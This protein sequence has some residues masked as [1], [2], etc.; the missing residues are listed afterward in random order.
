MML[1]IGELSRE[2]GVSQRTLRFYEEVGLLSGIERAA[3][4]GRLFGPEA[5]H[6]VRRVLALKSLGL[7]LADIRQVLADGSG[8]RLLHALRTC[9]REMEEKRSVLEGMQ[10]HLETL[11][12]FWPE[13]GLDF[14]ND[15]WCE[16]LLGRMLARHGLAGEGRE[17]DAAHFAAELA[18]VR[19]ADAMPLVWGA[20]RL[21]RLARRHGIRLVPRGPA[22]SSLLFRAF[23]LWTCDALAFGLRPERVFLS[24]RKLPFSIPYLA[25]GE[26]AGEL[27]DLNRRMSPY[28]F[29]G[30]RLPLLDILSKVY[31]RLGI[32][33]PEDFVAEHGDVFLREISQGE[34]TRVFGLDW[35]SASIC[36]R[37]YPEWSAWRQGISLR[38]LLSET[39]VP[40]LRDFLNVQALWALYNSE[41][42]LRTSRLH[43]YLGL[44][45]ANSFAADGPDWAVEL[46][47]PNRGM[48]IFHEDIHALVQT[49]TGWNEAQVDSFR[50]RLGHG[51]ASEE[52]LSEVRSRLGEG[53]MERLVEAAPVVFLRAHLA[54]SLTLTMETAILCRRH[55]EIYFEEA[56]TMRALHGVSWD[57]VGFEHKVMSALG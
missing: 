26:F 43:L 28:A 22:A 5:V 57:D 41:E 37:L 21:G 39:P 36:A 12:E 34:P 14:P 55:R 52:E 29:K 42:E 51:K 2:V 17:A 7:R 4:G 49:A 31:G 23:G 44:V 19:A 24:G 6:G 53:L 56:D 1:T 9:C 46:L 20:W 27:E 25:P 16:V 47:R 54:G 3:G 48:I 18:A 8:A 11:T 50:R 35:D 30:Y 13:E 40:T 38:R 45:R 15:D 33:R 32:A 10:R